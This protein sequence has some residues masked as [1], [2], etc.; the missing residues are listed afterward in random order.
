VVRRAG[1]SGGDR[2][3]MHVTSSYHSDLLLA[4]ACLILGYAKS[5]DGWLGLGHGVVRRRP[6]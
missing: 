1:A 5:L 6:C 4:V 2:S 3:R